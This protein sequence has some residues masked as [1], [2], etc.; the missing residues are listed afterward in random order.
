MQEA[1]QNSKGFSLASTTSEYALSALEEMIY[2]ETVS[3]WKSFVNNITF[4]FSWKWNFI[5]LVGPE[6]EKF[7]EWN[8][9]KYHY[10]WDQMHFVSKIILGKY[11]SQNWYSF[12]GQVSS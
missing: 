9:G 5:S 1:G 10:S 3:N 4:F 2:K 8:S 7:F 6:E 11:S 12:L